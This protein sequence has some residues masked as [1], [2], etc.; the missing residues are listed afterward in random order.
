MSNSTGMETYFRLRREYEL[1]VPERFNFVRDVVDAWVA[2]AP[3]KPA[4]L[5]V[6]NDGEQAR[7]L[8]FGELST[9]AG[10]VARMLADRGVKRGDRVF[11]MLPRIPEW[12]LVMLGCFRLGAVPVPGTTLLTAR[13]IAFRLERS[14]AVAVVTDTQ[15][16]VRVEEAG[17][18][19]TAVLVCA[20]G[21]RPGWAS[22]LGA[23]DDTAGD[24]PPVADTLASDPL[25]IYFTS[26]TTGHPKMVL[27]THASLGIG[28]DVTA[29]FWMDLRADDL[30]WTLSD[31]G[32]AKAAWGM[33]FG[34][35]RIGA[36]VFL[37]DGR[38]KPDLALILR[39]IGRYRVTTFCAPPTLYRGFS[40]LDL[41]AFD[42][43]SLRHAVAAG[44]PLDAET[45]AVWR[46]ATGLTIHDGYGQ[47]ETANLVA[48]LPGV[49]VR[50]GS[51][52]L[53][54]PGFDVHVVDDDGHR[55]PPGEEGQLAVAVVPDRPVGMFAEYWLDPERTAQAF[56]NGYYYTGDRAVADED[57]YLWFVSR[58]DDIIISAGYRIGPFE[59][60]SALVEHP[61]VVEA[62][63]VGVPDRERGQVVRAYV[64]LAEGYAP[65]TDLAAQIQDHVKAVTAP[66]KY[67]RQVEFVDELPKTISGK[68]RRVELRARS[69]AG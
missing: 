33:L 5:A 3:D 4:L 42:W 53:P 66:Y 45:I 36:T 57:G 19:G 6:S 18:A 27:H 2:R 52:G 20:D 49:P 48:N 21:E 11:V 55:L 64:V 1:G 13:D 26:G 60:E 22:L 38:G 59:V 12:H 16:A 9:L 51:M 63:A 67:P 40:Q 10:R 39:L 69:A 28:H 62:A 8:T 15:G 43:S 7:S 47:T 68:I 58:A 50:P 24:V 37:W 34:Q 56:R 44:E 46:E 65:S 17:T 54:T 23:L 25:L 30:H 14:D 41:G 31:T 29:R 35:W 32:W 61:A